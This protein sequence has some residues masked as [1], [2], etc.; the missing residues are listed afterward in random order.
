MKIDDGFEIIDAVSGLKIKVIR[1]KKQNRLHI[2]HIGKPLAN[3]RD[4][5]FTR[6]G[7]LDGTGSELT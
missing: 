5:W 6:D 3:N 1:G 7:K 2:E 4:F